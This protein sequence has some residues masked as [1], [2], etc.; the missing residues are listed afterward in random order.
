MKADLMD[1]HNCSQWRTQ[2]KALVRDDVGRHTA[3]LI[4]KQRGNG[5]YT[6]RPLPGRGVEVDHVFECQALG[7]ALRRTTSLRDRFKQV[8]WSSTQ[9]SRQPIVVQNALSHAHDVHNRLP[10]LTATDKL[11]N[12]KKQGAFQVLLNRL[13]VGDATERSLE[14]EL[15]VKFA[16]GKDPFESE[17]AE[18]MAK[19]V[20]AQLQAIEDGYTEALRDVHEQ[21]SGT[22][23]GIACGGGGRIVGGVRSR[24]VSERA[25]LERWYGDDG[26]TGEV[27]RLFDQL[28]LH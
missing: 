13:A 24:T 20:V 7:E 9:L 4:T 3:T 10:F 12:D 11:S 21:E 16:A 23:S 8:D 26:L 22:G 15:R 17:E 6:L 19:M 2:L 18:M 25:Q 14:D 5:A 27:V 28:G 1:G